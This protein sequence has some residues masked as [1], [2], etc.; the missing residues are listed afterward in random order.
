MDDRDSLTELDT[1]GCLIELVR[2]TMV[3]LRVPIDKNTRLSSGTHEQWNACVELVHHRGS[4]RIHV[5]DNTK[6]RLIKESK[7]FIQRDHFEPWYPVF[8]RRIAKLISEKIVEPARKINGHLLEIVILL[9]L[10][11]EDD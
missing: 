8:S 10:V 2:H 9:E 1:V 11:M 3:Q 6:K 7:I 4:V 5:I